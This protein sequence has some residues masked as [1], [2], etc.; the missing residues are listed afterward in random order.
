MGN[1]VSINEMY[2]HALCH[3]SWCYAIEAVSIDKRDALYHFHTILKRCGTQFFIIIVIWS[4]RKE[5]SSHHTIHQDW[6]ATM[7]TRLANELCQIII[8][9]GTNISMTSTCRFPFQM[10]IKQSAE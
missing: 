5:V 7:F 9:S 3:I 4:L 8:K 1:L 10:G 6:Y 2:V